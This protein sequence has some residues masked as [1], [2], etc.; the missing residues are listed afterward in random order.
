MY[1][2]IKLKSASYQAL[3]IGPYYVKTSVGSSW[4]YHTFNM[5]KFHMTVKFPKG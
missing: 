4:E 2:S 3:V 1:I 5:V